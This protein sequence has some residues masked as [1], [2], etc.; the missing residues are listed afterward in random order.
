MSYENFEA[1]FKTLMGLVP[2]V[3]ARE[4]LHSLMLEGME[5]KAE[6]S[7]ALG[8]GDDGR[9]V[10]EIGS[11][12]FLEQNDLYK[13]IRR[14]LQIH[15]VLD[16]P[17]AMD[18]EDDEAPTNQDNFWL[19]AFLDNNV[20]L[21]GKKQ[22][23][24]LTKAVAKAMTP[25]LKEMWTDFA[26]EYPHYLRGSLLKWDTA[27]STIF[28]S[29]SATKCEVV[30]STNPLDMILASEQCEFEKSCFQFSGCHA[31]GTLAYIR[32]KITAF[33]YIRAKDKTEFP[34]YKKARAW[35]YVPESRRKF[36][37]AN[38]YGSVADAQ[39]RAISDAIST[40]L[41]EHAGVENLWQAI[42]GKRGHKED[43]KLYY[44]KHLIA[45]AGYRGCDDDEDGDV[46]HSP[47]S[48]N[49]FAVWFDRN[50][51]RFAM[52]KADLDENE[53]PESHLPKLKFKSAVCLSCGETTDHNDELQ[54]EECINKHTQ[55]SCEGCDARINEIDGAYVDDDFYCV[56]CANARSY[57]CDR[58]FNRRGGTPAHRNA[59]ARPVCNYCYTNYYSA[60]QGCSRVCSNSTLS[61]VRDRGDYCDSCLETSAVRCCEC[62]HRVHNDDAV[63]FEGASYCRSC[64]DA[65]VPECEECDNRVRREDTRYIDGVHLCQ[66]CATISEPPASRTDLDDFLEEHRRMA[67]PNEIHELSLPLSSFGD[68]QRVIELAQSL[69]GAPAAN[70]SIVDLF[71]TIA[72]E[73]TQP[74]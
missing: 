57:V 27:I 22:G 49:D 69:A 37:L 15:M 1:E 26:Q 70:R 43:H 4:H 53:K 66:T 47:F 50:V 55:C 42:M 34:F 3:V 5:A 61:Y 13:A 36:L 62:Y 68:Q 52:L 12:D 14:F 64:A 63:D 16:V 72:S 54:C 23:I 24:K 65:Y 59:E 9:K 31:N 33:V 60:C 25:E 7:K 46:D 48:P 44:P 17:Q 45:N 51:M 56:N 2:R 30:I 67:T 73:F 21:T 8:V 40:S 74:F 11:S 29:L 41:A 10:F 38:F 19:S 35:V 58:C 18:L 32:D 6:L 20:V 39:V 71:R 28:E